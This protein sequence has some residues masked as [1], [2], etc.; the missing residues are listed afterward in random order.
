MTGLILSLTLL[1]AGPLLLWLARSQRAL[2][3]LLDGFTL[4][5]VG[6]LVCLDIIPHATEQGG[7]LAIPLALA[8]LLVPTVFERLRSRGAA[9]AHAFALLLGM[10]GV[11]AHALVD[12]MALAG[13]G[14]SS[15]ALAVILHRLPVGI[16]AWWLIRPVYGRRAGWGVLV[17]IAVA[18]ALGFFAGESLQERAGS[19]AL[20]LFAALVAGSLLH[21]LLHVHGPVRDLYDRRGRIAGSFGALAGSGVVLL[22]VGHVHGGSPEE[23]FHFGGGSEFLDLFLGLS[24]E[25]AFPLLIA[26]LAAGLVFGFLPAATVAWLGRGGRFGSALRGLVFALPIPICS[27]GVIPIYK[28]LIERG[29]PLGAAMTLLV[30]A[31]ELGID[32]IFLSFTLLDGSFA[33]AR[34][35]AAATIA[36]AVGWTM[37][38]LATRLGGPVV[39][40]AP[41][42]LEGTPRERLG[43]GLRAGFVELVD[44]TAPWLLLGLALAAV[45]WPILGGDWLDAIPDWLEVP[46]FAFLGMPIYVCA[47]GATPIAAVLVAQGV[48]P[49]AALAFL[50]TGPATNVTTFGVLSQLHGRRIAILFAALMVAGAVLLGVVV[51]HSIDS[52]GTVFDRGRVAPEEVQGDGSAPSSDADPHREGASL[53][54]ALAHDHGILEVG[55]LALLAALFIASLLRQGPRG[56]VGHVI[57][58]PE[59]GHG[60]THGDG[61]RPDDPAEDP[62]CTG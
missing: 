1:L 56:F 22:S 55:S 48:S 44:D 24:L 6:G 23:S 49:G 26:Y 42:K 29:A 54:A 57:S 53:E 31:P 50:L 21:V 17:G 12:G 25:S 3:A 30:A 14:E 36:L 43:K 27:C 9:R 32:A 40:R 11:G 5:A 45:A 28:G 8:G 34:I 41:P 47:S 35:I 51:D 60:H 18:T 4:F 52:V 46:V 16:A 15:L 37:G 39:G 61:H 33:I 13:G 19:Q 10:V 62:C 38:Q 58:P 59:G 7:W 2:L 20:G